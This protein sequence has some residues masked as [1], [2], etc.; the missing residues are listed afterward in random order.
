M[1]EY[2][3]PDRSVFTELTFVDTVHSS[4]K[5]LWPVENAKPRRSIEVRALIFS[6]EVPVAEV[7]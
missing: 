7:T 1:Y 5:Q 3:G 2:E 4:I 6:A